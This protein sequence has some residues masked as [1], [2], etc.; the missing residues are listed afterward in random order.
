MTERTLS[1]VT[2][3]ID[4]PTLLEGEGFEVRRPIPARGWRRSARSSCSI[5]LDR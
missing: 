1:R 2:R 3:A 4:A 5:I